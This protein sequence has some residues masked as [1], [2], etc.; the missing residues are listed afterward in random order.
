MSRAMGNGWARRKFGAWVTIAGSAALLAACGGGGGGGGG[1][2]PEPSGGTAPGNVVLQGTAATGL[3]IAGATVEARCASGNGS[4]S[5]ASDG[6]FTITINGGSLPCVLR[7]TAPGGAVL[8]SGAEGSGSGSVTANLSPLSE[9][10]LGRVAGSDAAS[11]FAN[12][13]AAAQARITAAAL[14]QARSELRQALVGVLD[15][16]TLDPLK[17]ALVAATPGT[18]GNAFDQTLDQLQAALAS[19][20]LTLDDLK[21]MVQA[22]PAVAAVVVSS[23]LRPAAQNCAALRSGTYRWLDFG[24]SGAARIST[25]TVDAEQLT[26][27][28]PNGTVLSGTAADECRYSALSGSVTLLVAPSGVVIVRYNDLTNAG[29]LAIAFPEQAL[30]LS[31]LA[32]TWNFISYDNDAGQAAT[33]NPAHGALTVGASG[34]VSADNVC[35]LPFSFGCEDVPAN[36]LGS[37]SADASGGFSY[38]GL[39]DDGPTRF[40]VYRTA[41]GELLGVG[42]SPDAGGV[43]VATLQRTL[44]LPAV[45]NVTN[46]WNFGIGSTGVASAI[47]DSSV[48]IQAADA[49]AGT[50]T[51]V[52]ASDGRVDSLAI[53]QPRTGM[54]LRA[55][56]SSVLT[57][58]QTL[59][60]AEMI[61]L[62]VPGV[63][64]YILHSGINGTLGVS[65]TKP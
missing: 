19:A 54:R 12:F 57:N 14:G 25:V 60:F 64:V 10:M 52:R 34:A 47:G 29:R 24:A 49:T 8:H 15:L 44:A 51:R 43:V 2:T 27:S 17:D 39:F 53:N 7:V 65:V 21:L 31:Q 62:P 33:F 45:G 37:F 13:D 18:T 63:R 32:G 26:V 40:F 9:L 28:F 4:A 35:R 23:Q 3:A 30:P 48:T 50:Y 16:G 38:L 6:R 59:S 36:E 5:T 41:S 55:A 56:G 42:L 46:F 58:G 22:D 61:S 1:A 20:R 11:L